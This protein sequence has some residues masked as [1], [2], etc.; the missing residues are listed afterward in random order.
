MGKNGIDLVAFWPEY[1]AGAVLCLGFLLALFSQSP[2]VAIF[3]TVCIGAVAARVF[4]VK[5]AEQ[6]IGPFVLIISALAVGL[7]SGMF[8]VNRI[9]IMV[10]FL[11]SLAISYYLH[12]KKIIKTFKSKAFL[13]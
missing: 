3:T 5:R 6:P 10:L 4:F 2:V 7:I 8:F 1:L 11:G 12:D 13:K 9:L